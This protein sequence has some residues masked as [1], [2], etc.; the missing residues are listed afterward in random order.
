[1]RDRFEW[2]L[3]S[4]LTPEQ[5][6]AS[7]ASDLSL[8]GEFVSLIAYSIREQVFRYRLNGDFDTTFA[9]EK[10]FRAEEEAKSWSPFI[11]VGD[12]VQDAEFTIEQDRKQ[13][14]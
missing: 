11:D 6:A 13:R 1:M 14:Y 9:I 7:L 10:P 5:F 2:D 4:T 3:N 8:G 12:P